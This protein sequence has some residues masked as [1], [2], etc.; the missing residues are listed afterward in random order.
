MDGHSTAVIYIRVSTSHQTGERDDANYS[1]GPALD[2]QRQICLNYYR[3]NFP[4]RPEPEVISDVG[5]TFNDKYK[6]VNLDRLMERLN[7]NSL[8]IIYEISR[9]GRNV[10]QTFGQVYECVELKKSMIYSVID[11]KLFGVNRLADM[12]FFRQSV[13]AEAE[14]ARRSETAKSR[15]AYIRSIG[16]YIGTVPFGKQVRRMATEG[17]YQKR[18]LVNNPNEQ[19]AIGIIKTMNIQNR[20]IS[21]IYQR[22][23]NEGFTNKGK[24]ISKATI[25][26]VIDESVSN[27]DDGL[28]M[29]LG[30]FNIGV[31]SGS[32]RS[33]YGKSKTVKTKKRSLE[34]NSSQ[35]ITFDNEEDKE[36]GPK[37]KRTKARSRSKSPEEPVDNPRKRSLRSSRNRSSEDEDE[38]DEDGA[39]QIYKNL[40]S[41]KSPK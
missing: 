38:E 40:R 12:D 26:K 24:R 9:L 28:S 8:I 35:L 19:R 39:A 2:G 23:L 4:G 13:E 7:E 16:G 31:S 33:K 22:L 10:Y 20:G 32:T 3:E 34:D 41:S 37:V 15:N 14:S 27:P 21:E 36:D 1:S 29:L 30:G 5:S 25:R 18:V 17:N 11:N 6:L